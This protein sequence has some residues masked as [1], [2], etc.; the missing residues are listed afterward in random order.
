[1]RL[2]IPD[3][4]IFHTG[5]SLV[6]GM[7]QDVE[8]STKIGLIYERNVLRQDQS[9]AL[10][11]GLISLWKRRQVFSSGAVASTAKISVRCSP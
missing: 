7:E 10:T 8:N 3:N 4:S 11:K 2:C 6:K 9:M 1:M 5:M